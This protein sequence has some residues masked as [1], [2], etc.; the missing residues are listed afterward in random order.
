MWGVIIIIALIV[1]VVFSARELFAIIDEADFDANYD[2][3]HDKG[4]SD[5]R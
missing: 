4:V 5:E 1:C 3:K 2:N